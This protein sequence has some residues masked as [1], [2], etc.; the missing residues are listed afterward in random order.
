MLTTDR[1]LQE[2]VVTIRWRGPDPKVQLETK[3]LGFKTAHDAARFAGR[4]CEGAADSL[5]FGPRGAWLMFGKS[6][7]VAVPHDR[8]VGWV[9]A[10][11]GER[12]FERS[13]FQEVALRASAFGEYEQC[14]YVVLGPDGTPVRVAV[15]GEEDDTLPV[16]SLRSVN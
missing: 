8:I 14:G 4:N 12:R 10:R 3:H 11:S 1:F 6:E 7:I 5:V 16:V 2:F 13:A 15:A 9:R